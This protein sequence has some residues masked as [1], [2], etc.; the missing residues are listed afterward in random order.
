MYSTFQLAK[1]YLHYYIASANGK[2]HGVHSPFVFD[3]ITHVLR[4]RTIYDCYTVIEKLR[5][6]LLK[7]Q[8]AIEVTDYGA[9]SAVIKGN[10]RL[11]RDIA[12]SSLK[13]KKFARLLYRIVHYYQPQTL[14]ELG[15]SFGIT[16]SYL[17]LGNPAAKVFTL[18]GS[19]QI[20]EIAYDNFNKLGLNNIELV[21]GDFA[22]SLPALLQRSGSIHLAFIDGNHQKDPTLH[23]FKLLSEKI[24]PSSILIFDDIH[25][26]KEMEQAWKMIRDDPSVKMTIDLF[27]MGLVFFN[28]GFKA[29]QHFSIRF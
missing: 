25:W 14:V 18:E 6:Q 27:F 23:Y 28:T 15:T 21:K 4:D 16:T 19:E 11:V 13:N 3:F 9:G 5:E 20:S 10:T 8:R 22:T 12:R 2:G 24:I 7:D 29:K 17:A 1:K 26:S